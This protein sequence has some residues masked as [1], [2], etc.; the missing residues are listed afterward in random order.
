[1]KV[2]AKG[3][4]TIPAHIREFL[5]IEPHSEVDFEIRENR[6]IIHKTA[7]KPVGRGPDRFAKMRGILQGKITTDEWMEATRGR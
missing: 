5:G 4:V 6:V 3:Q 2:T 7:S 1:M